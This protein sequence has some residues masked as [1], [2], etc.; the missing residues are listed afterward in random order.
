M[1]IICNL[2]EMWKIKADQKFAVVRSY[3]WPI[4]EVD[5]LPGLAP[6]Q[7]L[8]HR[9]RV[10]HANGEWNREAFDKIYAPKFI[11][12]L[13]TRKDAL[14]AL[15]SI[16]REACQKDIALGCFC[17]EEYLCHRII[18]GEVFLGLGAEV[19]FWSGWIPDGR[20]LQIYKETRKQRLKPNIRE[21]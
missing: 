10:L 6:S 2:S 21:Q 13:C 12:E 19:Q 18:L 1:I 16:R 15:V 8:F 5:Q 9:Y 4:F 3:R 7:R 11:T 17:K 20:Y 14:S